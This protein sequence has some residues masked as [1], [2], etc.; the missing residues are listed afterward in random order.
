MLTRSIDRDTMRIFATLL[1][2]TLMASFAIAQTESSPAAASPT[3]AMSAN[4]D[5]LQS[6]ASQ[7]TVDIAHMRIE[8]W[9]ADNASRQQ[10]QGNADSLQRNL[11]SA[12]PSLI[13]NF[14][15]APGDLNAGFKLYRNLNAL[16]DV[17][18]SFTEAAGAFGPK[19]DYEAL[20]QQA[21]IID[22]VRRNLADDLERMT[23]STQAEVQQLRTQVQ[24]L[25]QAA[26]PPPPPKKVVVDNAEPAKKPATHKKKTTPATAGNSPASS[27]S[28]PTAAPATTSKSQ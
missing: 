9:K 23:A 25:R 24:T 26:I 17:L 7:A 4:L 6:A 16:Y 28:T 8:K 5:R 19:N 18:A 11:S 12:L 1:L 13:A 2:I 21:D 3:A 10:A 27:G 22:S 20:A 14:R 15:S